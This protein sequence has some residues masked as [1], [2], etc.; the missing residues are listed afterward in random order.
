MGALF[1]VLSFVMVGI[2]FAAGE[3]VGRA[4]VTPLVIAIAAGVI[5]LWLLGLALRMFK[6]ARESRN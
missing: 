2:A 3:S 4:G 1:L 5:A 6:V